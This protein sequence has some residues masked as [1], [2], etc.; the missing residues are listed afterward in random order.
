[1]PIPVIPNI[2]VSV[3]AAASQPNA[4][5]MSDWHACGTSHCRAGWIV[6]L[7][8]KAGYA[9]EEFVG[10][11]ALAALII[12]RESGYNIDPNRFF[13]SNDEARADMK[14]LAEK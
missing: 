2:H 4:L 6:H 11:P 12:Y 13:D 7:A 8:G 5:D 3:Y 1:M 10:D 9:L 14:R